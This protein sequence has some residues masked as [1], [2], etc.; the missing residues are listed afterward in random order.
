MNHQLPVRSSWFKDIPHHH[1]PPRS[2]ETSDDLA[3]LTNLSGQDNVFLK[4]ITSL[5][6]D[7]YHIVGE[8]NKVY[9]NNQTLI[10]FEQP[11]KLEVKIIKPLLLISLTTSFDCRCNGLFLF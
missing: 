4:K 9:E 6:L 2:L 3:Q 7:K 1:Q 10:K 11:K 8:P 5:I